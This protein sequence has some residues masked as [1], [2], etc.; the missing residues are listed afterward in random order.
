[1]VEFRG[2]T[3]NKLKEDSYKID[4]ELLSI[5]I[6]EAKELI[7]RLVF[8]LLQIEQNPDR[9]KEFINE[10][11]RIAHN[12]K[13]SAGIVG[14]VE[15]KDV[16][17]ELENL[18]SMVRDNKYV[19]KDKV[20]DLLLEFTDD[21]TA[22]FEGD[23]KNNLTPYLNR[24]I[25]IFKKLREEKGKENQ[26]VKDKQFNVL[27][28]PESNSLVLT[29]QQKETVASWQKAGK[30]V[31]GINV[32][33]STE[34]VFPGAS[35]L[36]FYNELQNFGGILASNPPKERLAEEDFFEY[37]VVLLCE[38]SLS[39]D[40]IK[41]IEFLSLDAVKV[42][43]RKWVPREEQ[44]VSATAGTIRVEAEKI[45]KLINQMGKVLTLKTSLLHLAQKG[46]Y[47]EK[48]TWEQL[49]KTLQE[50]DQVYNVLQTD[51]LELR[52]VPIKQLFSRFPKSIRDM[53]KRC[54]KKVE[55]QFHGEETEI[56]KQ[57]VEE[58][59]DPLTHL[60]RNAIDHG[61]ES[62]EERV[63][64][65]K[66]PKGKIIVEARQEGGYIIIRLT[67][68]GQGLDME[69]IRKKAI[70]AGTIT[71]Q[72]QLSRQEILDLIFTPGLSTTEKVS[73]LS[74]RGVGLDIVKN[75]IQRLRGSIEVNTE[76]GKS[77]TFSLKIPLTLA[78]IQS[79]M[80]ELGGQIFGIPVNDIAQN[81]VIKEDEI[82]DVNGKKVYYRYPE[83]IPLI[84]LG[85]KFN[86]VCEKNPEQLRIVIINYGRSHVG[87]IVEEL[88]GLEE[89]M[90][91]R[92]NK[93]LGT[94]PDIA[95]ASL[96]GSGDIA[97]IIDTQSIVDSVVRI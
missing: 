66:D 95:G 63:K 40:E 93:A 90:I 64:V 77:T 21:V 65:G 51:I 4:A 75:A 13:G 7:E 25:P 88:L 29:Q 28:K 81:I 46:S 56:D 20:I 85:E 58:L 44:H 2:A 36:I 74:G 53:A 47:Q 15:L 67:D 86:F 91:K 35:A 5:F 78:I 80:V 84:D 38:K 9:Q 62:I 31:Y 82:H 76:L 89:V 54:G 14:L 43:I 48:A 22:F 37:K 68:D 11:F 72:D 52:M 34:T 71:E 92:V 55:V 87:L 57:I 83:V 16:V 23:N 73:D 10:M 94:T 18:F 69:K 6:N 42:N 8:I 39:P 19:L 26:D 1:M 41:K 45:D 12:I 27:P 3:M 17:H 61:I 60:F 70:L 49:G 96:L 97:L 59:I 30:S 33:F 32:L 79:F 50:L 24:W